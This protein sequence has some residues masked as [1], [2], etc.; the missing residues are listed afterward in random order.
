MVL[1]AADFSV[2]AVGSHTFSRKA[3]PKKSRVFNEISGME[4]FS[5]HVENIL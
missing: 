2:Y 4:I 5:P 1:C 3:I